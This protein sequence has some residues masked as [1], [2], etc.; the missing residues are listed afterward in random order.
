[1][2]DPLG[3]QL[4][5]RLTELVGVSIPFGVATP[6]SLL[7]SVERIVELSGGVLTDHQRERMRPDAEQLTKGL[8]LLVDKTPA[9]RTATTT[10]P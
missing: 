3:P 7:D 4:D 8:S 10:G 5:I 1:M 9:L 2:S 6:D